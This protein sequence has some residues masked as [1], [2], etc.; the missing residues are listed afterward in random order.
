MSKAA[1]L[2]ALIGSQTA[3]SNRNLIIN[4]AM[5]VAQRGT[6]STGVGA[7]NGV[8]PCV[9]RMK[10]FAGNTAGRATVSQV[11]D[12][13][14]GFANALKFECTTADTSIAA[15]E[16]FGL[17][18][19]LE[20]QD[21]QHLKKGTSGAKSLT[22]SF[23]V[24]GN[25]SATYTAELKDNDNDRH[26]TQTFDVTTSWNR[27]S[28][29]FAPDTTGELD[30]DNGG[31]FQ[32]GIWLHAGSDFTGG[33]FASNTWAA[34]VNA[35]RVPPS[36]TSFFDSTD[37]TFF[38]TGVQLEVGETA[39]PFEHEDYGTTLRKGYRY[40]Y[41]VGGTNT[42][43]PIMTAAW[44]T[45]TALAGTFYYPVDMRAA[46]S[47]SKTGS[48]SFLGAGGTVG[49]SISGGGQTNTRNIQLSISSGSGG[50]VG[51]AGTLRA[52]NDTSMRVKFDSEL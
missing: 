49:T 23:Y 24:K 33:T 50:T 36:A 17:I 11:A 2:A 28:L 43:E 14:D 3:L 37:R 52:T 6:S 4:G 39:T 44:Y 46:P 9:D 41:Q 7:S 29:T 8:F 27:I 25:A 26:N 45:T 38:I 30:D 19:I 51:K 32:F 31:S 35:N 42:H 22:L 20:G 12:V 13:H 10:I 40:Y 48:I 5:N 1:E 47:V 15:G 16:N 18:Q 21:L 34:R